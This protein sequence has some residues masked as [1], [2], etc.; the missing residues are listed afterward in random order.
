M[1]DDQGAQVRDILLVGAQVSEGAQMIEIWVHKWGVGLK[2]P[3]SQPRVPLAPK[4][5]LCPSPVSPSVTLKVSF[6]HAG[7][8]NPPHIPA[9]CPHLSLNPPHVPAPCP[10]V[11]P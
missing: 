9:P 6:H 4:P 2:G 7:P 3:M 1:R 10:Q 5:T 8:L 11:L